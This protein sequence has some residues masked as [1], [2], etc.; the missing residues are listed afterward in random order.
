M[1]YF[2][3]VILLIVLI[4]WTSWAQES[5]QREKLSFCSDNFDEFAPSVSADGKVMVFQS[6]KEGGVYKL[7]ESKMVNGLWGAPLPIKTINNFG[8]SRDLVAGASI[9]HDGNVLYFCASYSTGW[10]DM[11][12]YYAVRNGNEWG[13]PINFGKVI[14]SEGYDGF[15]SVSADGNKM[16]FVRYV[17]DIDGVNCFKIMATEKDTKGNWKVPRELPAPINLGCDKAPR[18]MPDGKTIVFSSMRLGGKGK[19]D[20]Y[21]SK[22][23][24]AGDW[25]EPEPMDFVN[26]DDQEQ[27]ATVPASGDIMYY[28][29]RGDIVKVTIPFKYRQFK[30][31]TLQGKIYDEDSRSA[32]DAEL[33]VRDGATSELLSLS[34]NAPD[35]SFTI[36]LTAGKKYFITVKKPGYSTYFMSYDLTY[37]QEYKE[38]KEDVLLF[39]SVKM[40][41]SV[42]DQDL[43]FPVD[44]QYTLIDVDTR[45]EV[46]PN[47]LKSQQGEYKLELPI[48]KKYQ[49]DVKHN[50]YA[51]YTFYIDLKADVRYRNL[52]KEIEL[53]P[54]KKEFSLSIT[55]SETGEGLLVDVLLTNLDMDEQ[56][57]VQSTM[58]RDGKLVLN[59]R[60]GNRYNVEVK[61]PK[62]YA[63]FNEN[64]QEGSQSMNIGLMALKPGA[65]LLLKDIT[66]AFNSFELTDDS[67]EELLR[68]IRLMIENPGMKIEVAGHTDN[69]GGESFNKRLSELRA[70]YVVNFMSARQ[71][72]PTRL[73]AVG[74]GKAFPMV[75]NDTEEN[76]A[77]NR[78]LEL[79]VLST[80]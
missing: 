44:Y 31:V 39:K 21:T 41:I 33:E 48:G 51:P 80:N 59:L 19:F 42:I 46:R 62:G 40:D 27:Y 76:R 15:P 36:V 1:C 78:R 58:L 67:H 65:K 6:N 72:S 57:V 12:L 73:K 34:K 56:L 32:L 35:G 20:L 7:Y 75:P 25:E 74:Y 68:V 79:K 5:I 77:K 14:N 2:R 50:K 8:S 16:Y 26:T 70:Q 4:C 30:N 23:N 66:F 28:H 11:D 64:I 69:V 18:I 53:K 45:Q 54:L 55:D 29:Y 63:F 10:G 17:K 49:V 43:Y 37:L 47:I 22:L 24:E 9:S 13:N 61:N 60:E 38:F 52:E 71:I 3:K